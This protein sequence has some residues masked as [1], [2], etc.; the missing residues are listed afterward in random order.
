[1]KLSKRI[2]ALFMIPVLVLSITLVDIKK[3]Y[4]IEPI[5]MIGL[6]GTLV[7]LNLAIEESE[8]YQGIYNSDSWSK[9]REGWEE[10]VVKVG[11][12]HVVAHSF[13][14]FN[15]NYQELKKYFKD[16]KGLTEDPTEEECQE[17]CKQMYLGCHF[18]DNNFE[19][20]KIITHFK[21]VISKMTT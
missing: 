5:G 18:G 12:P 13:N 1:M 14:P 6:V 17:Y 7:G 10:A 9:L 16:K 15:D 19:I 21:I 11:L 20:S 8:L 2:I 3:T 4:A